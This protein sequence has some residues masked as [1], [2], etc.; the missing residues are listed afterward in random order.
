MSATTESLLLRSVDRSASS[1][2]SSNFRVDFKSSLGGRYL[3]SY[4]RMPVTVYNVNINNFQIPFQ[5]SGVPTF[6]QLTPGQ[7]TASTLATEIGTQMT[8]A[9]GISVFTATYNTTT[10]KFTINSSNNFMLIY[11][12]FPGASSRYLLGFN[13]AT[14]T[15]AT[16]HTSDNVADL[17]YPGSICINV[18]ESVDTT[19]TTTTGFNSTFYFPINNSFGYPQYLDAQSLPQTIELGERTKSLTINITDTSG[20]DIDLN[21]VEWKC[22]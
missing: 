20:A 17:S 5:E 22:C 7:Y 10:S 3:L 15:N 21:G 9:S 1:T 4:L 16:S 13:L 12:L 2:S 6:A 19:F 8:A 14:T 11:N 18:R